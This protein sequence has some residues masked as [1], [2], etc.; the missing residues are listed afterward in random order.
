M[1]RLLLISVGLLI[2]T[3]C[4][5]DNSDIA[6]SGKKPRLPNIPVSA[7]AGLQANMLGSEKMAEKPAEIKT[8]MGGLIDRI[9]QN[10]EQENIT[11]QDIDRGWYYGSEDKQKWGTPDTWIWVNEGNK[12]HW[13]SPAALEHENNME[14]D[15]MCRGTGG[16]YVISCAQSNL[17]HCEYIPQSECVCA[18]G[19]KWH[20]SQGCILFKNDNFVEISKEDLQKGWYSGSNSQ[21]K[22]NTPSNWIWSE[23]GKDSKWRNQGTL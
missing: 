20:D 8:D 9:N 12:S 11:V 18:D 22:L 3:A 1:K 6:Q 5:S 21:K 7:Q 14:S 17:P 16:H 23:N 19:T 15:S 4:S 13:I 10:L 2:L